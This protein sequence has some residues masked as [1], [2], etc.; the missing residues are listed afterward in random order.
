[1]T[2]AS[3]PLQS[4]IA[5]R[6]PKD[7]SIS[8][9]PATR[10]ARSSSAS[11][12][13]SNCAFGTRRRRFSAWRRPISPTPT[14]SF[15]V[16][17]CLD[18]ALSGGC[19]GFLNCADNALQIREALGDAL[20]RRNRNGVELHVLFDDHPAGVIVFL[21]RAEECGEVDIA[22]PDDREDFVFD[23]FFK[24]PFVLASFSQSLLIAVFNVD[25]AQFAFEFFCFFHRVGMSVVGVAGV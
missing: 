7:F 12:T 20:R 17:V 1:M 14:P 22:L 6:L 19:A 11:A 4:S 21:Q 24:R 3:T 5:S 9:S 25:E 15:F 10:R 23:G 8:N 18:R 16:I 2:M 13:A